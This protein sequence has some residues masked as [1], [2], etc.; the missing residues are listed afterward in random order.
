MASMKR[1][2]KRSLPNQEGFNQ[3]LT[4]LP[5]DLRY[6]INGELKMEN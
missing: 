6:R 5:H 1:I 4:G 2:K 3:S